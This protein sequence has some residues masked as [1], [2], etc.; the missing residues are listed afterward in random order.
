MHRG[1]VGTECAVCGGVPEIL[2]AHHGDS[3]NRGIECPEVHRILVLVHRCLLENVR[4]VHGVADGIVHGVVR[5]A[6][7]LG[8]V[9]VL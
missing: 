9:F 4:V 6:V 5:V 7:A 3:V 8:T 2:E 1:R